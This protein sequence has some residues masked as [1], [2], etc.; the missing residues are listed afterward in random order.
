MPISSAPDSADTLCP[1]AALVLA[2]VAADAEAAE[3]LARVAPSITAARRR[4]RVPG[5]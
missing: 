5:A 2:V 1:F 4:S 3:T